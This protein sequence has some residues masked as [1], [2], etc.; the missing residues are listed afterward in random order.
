MD[1]FSFYR[2]SIGD[3]YE[4]Y[5]IAHSCSLYCVINLTSKYIKIF[6][7]ENLLVNYF[8]KYE[9]NIEKIDLRFD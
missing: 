6:L 3:S 1:S 5:Y 9:G 4:Y 7:S 2:A 8:N